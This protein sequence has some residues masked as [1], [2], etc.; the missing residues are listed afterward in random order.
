[1]TYFEYADADADKFDALLSGLRDK[2]LNPEWG[3]VE[4]KPIVYGKR[5]ATPAEMLKPK[6]SSEM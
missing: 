6:S 4:E 3:Y 1:M 5:T 2:T